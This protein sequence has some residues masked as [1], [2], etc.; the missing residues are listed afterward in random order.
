MLF[1]E[2]ER[3]MFKANDIIFE[4]ISQ[5]VYTRVAAVH[6]KTGLEAVVVTPREMMRS[7]QEKVATAKLRYLL[8]KK[9]LSSTLA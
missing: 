1:K 7:S 5:G 9:G 6:V 4:F 8:R 3:P 2:N